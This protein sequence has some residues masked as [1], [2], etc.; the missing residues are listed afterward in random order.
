M[1]AKGSREAFRP[2][3]VWL[4]AVWAASCMT[5]SFL[6]VGGGPKAR[7]TRHGSPALD[8][9]EWY[10]TGG[11]HESTMKTPG[12]LGEKVWL[13]GNLRPVAGIT[14]ATTVGCAALAG[15]V[16]A[17]D[18]PS[19]VRWLVAASCLAAAAAVAVLAVVAG[20]PR[21]AHRG[22]V[23]RVRLAPTAVHE[24]PLEVV[25]C[26]FLGSRE[27]DEAGRRPPEEEGRRVTTL[28]MRLAERAVDCRERPSFAPWGKWE[29][30]SVVFDGRW[31]QPL[32]VEVARQLSGWLVEAKRAAA[33]RSAT[34]APVAA[35]P[36]G[37]TAR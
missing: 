11:N 28:V 30:G 37:A 12:G 15:T 20:R 2:E 5:K 1:P 9:P 32:S 18:A 14:V 23:L 7:F 33:A 16:A 3:S 24:V 34:A 19:A 17:V 26:F 29:D 22:D 31:C 21:L 4:A 36:T 6:A 13:R 25:E 27:L 8:Q 10:E 35:G